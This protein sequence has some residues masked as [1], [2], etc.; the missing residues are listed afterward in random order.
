MRSALAGIS[1]FAVAYLLSGTLQVPVLVY[2]PVA[3]HLSIARTVSG[4][5]FRYAGDL[6]VAST[7][8]IVAAA[9]SR[10]LRPRSPLPVAAGA[11][12]SLVALDLLFYL[13]RL[14]ASL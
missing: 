3:H 1:A 10:R 7:A 2:D 12:L 8:G 6:I 4:A 9:V 13:S 14:L 11:A 5:S